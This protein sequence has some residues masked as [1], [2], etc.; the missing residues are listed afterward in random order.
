M[1]IE[2]LQP[3][4]VPSS[5]ISPRLKS[6]ISSTTPTTAR[7]ITIFL[8]LVHIDNLYD[9]QSYTPCY[10][11]RGRIYGSGVAESKGGVAI[12]LAALQALQLTQTLE[13]ICCGVLLTTDDSLGGKFSKGVIAEKAQQSN[14]VVGL[15]YGGLQGEIV[16][17]CCGEYLYRIEMT[18]VKDGQNEDIPDVVVAMCEKVL[19]WKKLTSNE[20]GVRVTVT[21]HTAQTKSGRGADHASA[22]LSLRFNDKK[23]VKALDKQIRDIAD[24]K[25]LENIQIQIKRIARRLPVIESE[26]NK[27]FFKRVKKLAKKLEVRA[28]SAHRNR[29]SDICHV[30]EGIA[31]LEGL[32]P[33]GGDIQSSNEYIMRDS[34]ID[35]ASLL[36]MLILRSNEPS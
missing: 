26:E 1:D 19:A 30:P 8:L 36:A 6:A 17:S 22:S 7:K 15:K 35:R 21:S 11:E 3:V 18:N 2:T 34:L 23:Q 25:K 29:P 16:I 28:Q 4:G 31:V 33:V 10:Q 13:K 27:A 32:G 24:E 5:S 20:Q 12:I 9:Y 14:C